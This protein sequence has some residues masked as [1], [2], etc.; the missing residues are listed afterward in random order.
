LS[1]RMAL[2]VPTV[3]SP[4]IYCASMPGLVPAIHALAT[5]HKDVDSRDKPGLTTKFLTNLF[6]SSGGLRN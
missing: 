5:D 2:N 4:G 1:M 3:D 6:S